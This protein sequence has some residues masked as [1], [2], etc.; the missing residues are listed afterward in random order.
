MKLATLTRALPQVARAASNGQ[1]KETL[2][3]S[4]V[5]ASEEATGLP[6]ALGIRFATV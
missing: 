1:S 3:T 6:G 4:L 2:R 5:Q